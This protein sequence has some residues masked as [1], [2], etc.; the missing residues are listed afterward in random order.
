MTPEHEKIVNEIM[1]RM[2]DSFWSRL[3]D[4][5]CICKESETVNPLCPNKRCIND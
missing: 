3:W 5:D 4:D 1:D 2:P